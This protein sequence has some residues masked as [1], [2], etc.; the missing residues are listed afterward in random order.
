MKRKHR[1]KRALGD[2]TVS[3]DRQLLRRWAVEMALR[4]PQVHSG[5][6]ALNQYQNIF[7]NGPFVDADIIGRAKQIETYVLS[8]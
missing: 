1:V 5:P 7:S 3:Q 4:W 8:Q 6:S 2:Y